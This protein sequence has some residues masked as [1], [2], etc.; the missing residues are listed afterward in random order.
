MIEFLFFVG[1]LSVAGLSM[2]GIVNSVFYLWETRE[3]RDLKKEFIACCKKKD[4]GGDE[5]WQGRLMPMN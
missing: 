1:A 4:A 3:R 2:Y 5:R